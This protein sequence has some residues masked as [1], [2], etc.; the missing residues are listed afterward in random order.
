MKMCI[1]LL[2]H[3]PIFLLANKAEYVFPRVASGN[4]PVSGR[5]LRA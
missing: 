4:S 3:V 1:L 5:M 2:K